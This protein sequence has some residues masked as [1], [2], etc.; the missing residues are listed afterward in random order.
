MKLVL[1]VA[2][3]IF[4]VSATPALAQ[5]VVDG[6]FEAPAVT[7]PS[8]GTPGTTGGAGYEPNGG[9]FGYAAAPDGNQVLHLQGEG[10]GTLSVVDLILGHTYDVSFF[11]A[12]R[13]GFDPLPVSL[14]FDGT[15]VGT[16]TPTSTAFTAFS[17]FDFTAD[18]TTGTLTFAGLNATP[19]AANDLNTAV[20][21][22]SV[23][24]VPE[25]GI[26]AMMIMGF[27][28][29]GFGLR[30]RRKQPVRVSFA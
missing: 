9:A 27:G 30:Y 10:E 19:S 26:W 2:A 13:T 18:E 4:A 17:G 16:F 1:S 15:S 25:P 6:S 20:D 28:L 24:S 8:Y 11:A 29:V 5:N 23:A 21:A 22:V 14:S 12:A 7:S 3:A